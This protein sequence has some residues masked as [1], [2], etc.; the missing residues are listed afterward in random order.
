[1]FGMGSLF[2]RAGELE[3]AMDPVLIYHFRVRRWTCTCNK[4]YSH[5]STLSKHLAN[6]IREVEDGRMGCPT[7][8]F[9]L[10]G[11]SVSPKENTT[12]RRLE[13]FVWKNL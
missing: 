11:T 4:G 1:M 8:K 13:V 9:A 3:Y 6:H 7:M 2:T 12:C 5:P 10:A